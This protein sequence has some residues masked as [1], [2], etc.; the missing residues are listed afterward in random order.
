MRFCAVRSKTDR[1]WLGNPLCRRGGPKGASIGVRKRVLVLSGPKRTGV[2]WGTPCVGAGDQKERFWCA[3]TRFGAVRSKTDRVWL[4]NP[5][6]RRGG[7]KG[8]S[9]GVR[10]RVLVLS[11]PK[12]TG[13]GWGTP[14]VGAGDQKE[15][16]WCAQTRF[17]AV[18][19][20]TDRVWLG[21]PL[22][23]RGGP[24]GA[25]IGVRKRVLVLSGPKRTGFGWGTPC[26]GAG[27]QKERQ[28]VCA[29]AFWCCPVQN[30]PGLVG[31]PPV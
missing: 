14:C 5:L 11:G 6:C 9:I 17:G 23:R 16:F 29:N 3:Q 22:C 18:R 19:S 21:N 1:V 7:P 2:G 24:K 20:K 12:R 13:V 8:A 15:R 27:D 28:L 30:G 31:E 10:K 25:S 26:V 4:G